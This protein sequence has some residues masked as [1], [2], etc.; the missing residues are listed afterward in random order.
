MKKTLLLL[1]LSCAMKADGN[2][3]PESAFL[4]DTIQAVVFGQDGTQVIPYSDVIRPSLS[5]DQ[6]SLDDLIFERLVY[7][8]AQKFKILADDDAVDKYLTMVQKQNNL[9]LDELKEIFAQ[10]GY[11]YEEGRDQFKML[12]TV[13]SML[14]FKI[15]SHVIVPRKMVEE[16]YQEHPEWQQGAFRLKVGFVPYIP[17]Q[18]DKQKKAIAY[19]AKSGKKMRG[20]EWGSP[21]WINQD[22][23][24]EDKKFIFDLK[25]GKT[26]QAIDTGTGFEI[27]QLVEKKDRKLIPLE[28]R[29][30]EIANTLRRP[31]Y[32]QL[33]QKYK[34][35]LFDTASI[36]YLNNN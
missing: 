2:A 30:Q 5:G 28:E 12:Q 25:P 33:M 23:V 10:S 3:V 24:A 19:M 36:V 14:D 7:L 35:H 34:D 20:I 6:R 22:D 8:D 13:N 21:F 31:I 17:G 32:E 4:I 18:E 15:R 9:T 16:Y 29:Y 26:S 11:S 1:L 27:Y